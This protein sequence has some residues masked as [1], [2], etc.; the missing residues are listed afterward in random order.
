MKGLSN[1]FAPISADGGEMELPQPIYSS[2]W[3]LAKTT[4]S[5]IYTGF[6]KIIAF[7]NYNNHENIVGVAQNNSNESY[8]I[9]SNN[10]NNK[11]ANTTRIYYPSGI[12][13]DGTTVWVSCKDDSYSNRCLLRWTLDNFINNGSFNYHNS[14]TT[15]TNLIGI[16]KDES[17]LSEFM[18]YGNLGNAGVVYRLK[19]DALTATAIEFPSSTIGKIVGGGKYKFEEASAWL[20]VDEN[21]VILNGSSGGRNTIIANKI[22]VQKAKVLN[23]HL[24]IAGTHENKTILYTTKDLNTFKKIDITPIGST[25]V[26]IIWSGNLSTRDDNIYMIFGT[27]QTYWCVK[28]IDNE[29]GVIA[30]TKVDIGTG[31]QAIETSVNN[32]SGENLPQGALWFSNSSDHYNRSSFNIY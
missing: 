25:I 7:D 16:L 5:N 4:T 27:S 18:A 6:D 32:I 2:Y 20:F 1:A 9:T 13:T 11:F 24:I 12:A 29:N 21:G 3:G 15:G 30:T 14:L 26:D 23:N 22:K 10:N 17:D 8:S 28:D 31:V 19:N